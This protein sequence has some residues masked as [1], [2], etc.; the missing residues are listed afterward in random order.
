VGPPIRRTAAL[1]PPSRL[2]AFERQNAFIEL[3]EFL[4]ELFQYSEEIHYLSIRRM[5]LGSAR[6][7][8]HRSAPGGHRVSSFSCP[9]LSITMRRNAVQFCT[10]TSL[11]NFSV[12]ADH[13][14]GD[15]PVVGIKRYSNGNDAESTLRQAV[16]LLI[17]K[18]GES[19]V[20][21]DP[22]DLEEFRMEVS[23]VHDAL[24]PA[25]P[26]ENLLILAGS[27]IGALETYNKRVTGRIGTQNDAYQGII[28][29]FQ[30]SLV[31]ITGANAE[32]VRSLNR[33]SEELVGDTGFKDLRSL[34][35]NLGGCLSAILD[36]TEREKAR[37]NTLVEN[38][39]IEIES[40]AKPTAALPRVKVN[41]ETLSPRKDCL[42]A[43][44]Q[45]IDKGTRHYAVVIVLNRVQPISA[46]FGREAGDWMMS[47]FKEYVE[48]QIDKSDRLY[49]WIGPAMVAILERPQALEHVRSGVRRILNRSLQE[50]YDSGSRSVMISLS[51]AWS[52]IL[53]SS[54]PEAVENQIQAFTASH[55]CQELAAESAA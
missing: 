28:R 25:L 31:K 17:T 22:A 35:A 39:Q 53:L 44:R 42:A 41:T 47:R 14:H 10:L 45:A 12:P 48:T 43:I 40:F 37:S 4:A 24:T 11:K 6:Q 49:H 50:I 38:L 52:V 18:L 34:Q 2:Y 54:T 36:A 21:E 23:A 29:M 33:I 3:S 8:G 46:R 26:P 55:G 1:R 27:A 20:E 30:H 19:A 15:R 32:C 13:S 51:A 5:D 9:T 16:A 7:A